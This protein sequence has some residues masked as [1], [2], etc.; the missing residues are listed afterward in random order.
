[1]T[2]S[3]IQLLENGELEQRVVGLRDMLRSCRL[4][5]HACEVD[6]LSGQLGKCRTSAEA[7]VS[8]HN[9]HHGEEPPI[10]GSRGSGTIFFTNCSL[11]CVFCQNY[12]IS[13]LGN[14]KPASA[15]TIA[16][17]MLALQERGCHNINWVTPTHVVPQAVEGVL[18]AARRGLT[19]PIVYNSSGYDSVEMVRLLDGIVDIYMPD[20]KYGDD[21][22][23]EKF[24]SAPG[25]FAVATAA[26][27]EM[28]RQVGEL[29]FDDDGVAVRG[30]IV[31]HLVLP[32]NVSRTD[33]ALR[34]LAHEISPD[35][36]VSIMN[37]FFPAHRAPAS[38]PLNRP[39][40]SGEYDQAVDWAEELDLVNGWIQ[41]DS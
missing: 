3:Y 10:S 37:Q 28:H 11:R 24:S 23:A 19:L 14:G 17:Y 6:R 21:E 25:Y 7:W 40:Q 27:R 30:L 16:G 8:S 39:L 20:L 26:I 22:A 36:F 4:C 41:G 34:F 33:L 29:Q 13:Q 15:E 38:P 2:A 1:M 31:R 9:D 18:L 5:G 32:E 12:P 35:T